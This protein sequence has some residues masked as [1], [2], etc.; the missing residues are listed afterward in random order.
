MSV[1]SCVA[2]RPRKPWSGCAGSGISGVL[3]AGGGAGG[4]AAR[5]VEHVRLLPAFVVDEVVRAY[6][7]R[8]R[9]CFVV[10]F[11]FQDLGLVD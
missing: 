4:R 1:C 7:T 6:G 5:D 9:R 11:G 3:D 10:G 8:R 2:R